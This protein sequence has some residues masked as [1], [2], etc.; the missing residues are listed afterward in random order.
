MAD[1]T[2]NMTVRGV[3]PVGTRAAKV[4]RGTTTMTVTVE[5]A[6]GASAGSVYRAPPIPTN[7]RIHGLSRISGDVLD[8]TANTPTL[9]IGFAPVDGNFTADPDA[10]ND[11]IDL[12]GS[13]FASNVIKDIANYGKRAWE[14]I[15]GLTADPGG[16]A[17]P[18]LSIV[19]AAAAAGGTLTL[20][21]VYSVD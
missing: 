2:K 17:V 5:V 6:A 19:D 10:L 3:I 12:S 16:L 18:T 11:G 14:F 9:D 4:E 1:D 20:E 15:S 21:L 13:A 7:A 8:A